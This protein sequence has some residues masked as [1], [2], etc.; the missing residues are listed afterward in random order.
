MTRDGDA[1]VNEPLEDSDVTLSLSV[2]AS[3][4]NIN[5]SVWSSSRL[6]GHLRSLSLPASVFLSAASDMGFPPL[7]SWLSFSLR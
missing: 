7:S 3:S 6:A 5:L 4:G 1:Y 2:R